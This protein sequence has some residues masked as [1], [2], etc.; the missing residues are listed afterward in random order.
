MKAVYIV[1][2]SKNSCFVWVNIKNDSIESF[3]LGWDWRIT[4][5]PAQR[6]RNV[7]EY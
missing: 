2:L 4:I 1:R 6:G 7:K 5:T 3:C